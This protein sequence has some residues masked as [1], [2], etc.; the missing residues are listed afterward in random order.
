MKRNGFTLVEMMA[1]IVL[2]ALLAVIGIAT[3]TNVNESAKQKTLESKK[4]QIRTS[5]IKW[6]KENNISNKT[7]ISVNALV[8][9]GYLTAEENEV[10]KIGVIENPVTGENMICNTVDISLKEGEY[11]ATV[12][13]G[14]QNCTLATQSLVDTNISIKVVDEKNIDKTGSGSIAAWTS[15]NVMIIVSS[16]SY[17]SRVTSI[18]YDFE[19][20][21]I[22]KNKSGKQKYTG[23]AYISEAA[24][25]NYYNVYHINAA[26]ILNTKI[27]VTYNIAGENSKS[28]AYT[29][30]IDKEEASASVSS[31]SEWLTVDKDIYVT[32]DDGK[33]S[34]PKYFYITKN[35]TD[36]LN[37]SNRYNATFKTKVSTLEIGKYYVWTEDIAGNRSV[38]PKII[39]ELNNVD[40]TVPACEVLFHGHVGNN[41]WYK[42]V[43]VTPGGKNTIKAG[44][45]G[46]NIGVNTTQNDP[47]YTAYAA[48]D[49]FN[50]GLGTTRTT[51]TPKAGV[52][53]YCHVKTMAGNYANNV[54]NLKLDMTPPKI[55]IDKTTDTTYTQIKTITMTI[56]DGLSGLPER[57]PF[58]WGWSKS[59]DC[60]DLSSTESVIPG[61]QHSDPYTMYIYGPNKW[62]NKPLTGKY[63]LCID[64]SQ[65][66]D[67]A[68]NRATGVNGTGG[69]GRAIFGPY[70][71]DNTKPVC[72][73]VG[74]K[75]DWTKGEY[76]VNQNCKDDKDTTDQSGCEKSP[77]SQYY[78]TDKTIK[79]DKIR[80]TDKAGNY[81]DCPVNVYLDNT[82]P[83]CNGVG[84]KT[85]WTKGTYTVQQKCKETSSDQSGCD[86]N[87]FTKD[88]TTSQTV[89]TDSMTISDK[90]GNQTSCPINVYLDNTPPTCG[91]ATGENTTYTRTAQT[92]YVG[93]D[94]GTDQSG[95]SKVLFSKRHSDT[96]V[97]DTID[98]KDKVG[99]VRT[100]GPYNYYVDVTKPDCGSSSGENT[101]YTRNSVT[102]SVGCSDANSGCTQNSF[103]NTWSS[104][105]VTGNITIR[106]NAGNT[107]SCGP[108]NVY[109]DKT[110]PT[111]GA[112]SGESTSWT[113]S[114][115]TISVACSDANVGCSQTSFS[116]TW[117]S[118][119]TTSSI[120]I[121][122]TLGNTR[123]CG[124]NV[125]VDKTR[126]SCSTSK[127]S[128][129]KGG[130]S[131]TISCSDG[132]SGVASC[133]GGSTSFSGLT[134]GQS[135]SV[136]DNVGNSGSCSVSVSSYAC[137]CT[138][139]EYNAAIDVPGADCK[140][141]TP[142]GCLGSVTSGGSQV[143][144][145]AYWECV[146]TTCASTCYQ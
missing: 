68:G 132:H 94:D 86:K 115:R 109:I 53:Y 39:F 37:A 21:T 96:T 69:G 15:Q 137:D 129:G 105:R 35:E 73:G 46:M 72:D 111:C 117:S 41:G 9:E 55:T 92:V 77:F 91:G 84:G 122:D 108:Y 130:V 104:T 141:W 107:R 59:Q 58:R 139:K 5:A 42:E 7:I 31:N 50:E 85:K 33:G 83:V 121:S 64:Y 81:T 124:V 49:T 12:N 40:K 110:A 135:Y 45:S 82:A 34:G 10:G 126:P 142:G 27:V 97:T 133:N 51:E 144:G 102:V 74:G 1:V 88:Y 140:C 100:C 62:F 29:I 120:Q 80:I 66:T 125:Y 123:R 90:V 98:I 23:N 67:Y 28:R 116:R 11:I 99:N 14:E 57:L 52:N 113:S 93:C 89:K 24:A 114:D 43:P 143:A 119:T 17:D 18:S 131:G 78:G 61:H 106:D 127:S 13:D 146:E 25:A 87:P 32:V 79:T 118:T 22:T 95:C 26:L 20:N 103:S 112:T 19:G 8:V 47:E 145:G 3:Y 56:S 138:T 71:F 128:T 65:I 38:K 70:Y 6:A 36:P 60:A 54:R 4:E 75:T 63:Y 101:T 16:S 2:V 134:S 44:I 48:F 136:T 76:T 30:R